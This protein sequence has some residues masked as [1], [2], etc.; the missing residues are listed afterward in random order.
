MTY[1]LEDD[2]CSEQGLR[3]TFEYLLPVAHAGTTISY[4]EIATRLANDLK[5]DGKVFPIHVGHVVGTLMERIL[6][7]D[8]TAPL[9]NVLVVNQGSK[10][11]SYGADGFLRARFHLPP[12]QAIGKQRRRT[13]V[14]QSAK[15][16]YTYDSWP[17]IYRQ[18]FKKDAPPTDSASL[19]DGTEADGMPPASSKAGRRF[20]GP[21][22]S[23]EHSKLKEYV[24]RHP[25]RVG[26][27]TKPDRANDEEMLLS[28]DEVDVY[29]ERGDVVHLVEVKSVR[30]SDPDLKRGVY[31]CI[32][33][34]AVFLAQR[35]ATTPDIRVTTTLVVEAEPPSY[36]RAL[37][38]LHGVR[39]AVIA[40]N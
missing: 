5:I 13:L 6:R 32:K 39:L 25:G 11:P 31:Q 37:A 24:L 18:L 2:L 1:S 17:H 7:L 20:G 16:V 36:I 15:T 10:Q 12:G 21:A 40:V 26:A 28:G 9:I 33:Y 35:L 8:S 14:A 27:P 30:S 38:K 22:E 3:H 4:G 29:F 34:R 23:K 19:I